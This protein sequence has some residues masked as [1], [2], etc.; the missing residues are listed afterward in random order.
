MRGTKEILWVEML[1]CLLGD[2]IKSNVFRGYYNNNVWF[3]R[4]YDHKEWLHGA[5]EYLPNI[6]ALKIVSLNTMLI[7]HSKSGLDLSKKTKNP[8][9]GIILKLNVQSSRDLNDVKIKTLLQ[10]WDIIQVLW[11]YFGDWRNGVVLKGSSTISSYTV[12]LLQVMVSSS[13]KWG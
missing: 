8:C 5:G 3:T 7:K 12:D 4:V 6:K 11:K 13:V 2:I 9:P 10:F 1:L